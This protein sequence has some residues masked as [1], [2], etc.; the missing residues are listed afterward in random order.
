MGLT[1][2]EKVTRLLKA[3]EK[4][5]YTDDDVDQLCGGSTLA[6]V[7]GVVRG[8]AEI[9]ILEHVI[10]CDMPPYV[11]GG[12]E[13]V[14]H[15]KDGLLKLEDVSR[16]NFYHSAAQENGGIGG[17][18]LREE[19]AHRPVFNANVLDYL[20]K[21][22]KLPPKHWKREDGNK[23][24]ILFWGTIYRIISDGSLVVRGLYDGAGEWCWSGAWLSSTWR[25]RDTVAIEHKKK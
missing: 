15:R 20:L 1:D 24:T 2:M 19:L 13:V 7:R 3:L 21:Y 8:H 23:Y 25:S 18:E 11:P 14:E 16:A 5:E 9:N 10:D 4:G 17:L 6:D 12:W 22:P